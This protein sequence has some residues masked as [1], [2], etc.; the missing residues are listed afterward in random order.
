MA[1]ELLDS[2]INTLENETSM[3]DC[4]SCKKCENVSFADVVGACTID[5]GGY[6]GKLLT[7]ATKHIEAAKDKGYFT[8]ETAGQVF[9]QA[10]VSSMQQAIQFELSHG[11]AQREICL[12]DAQTKHEYNKI[13]LENKELEEKKKVNDAQIEKINKDIEMEDK[14]IDKIT[15]DIANAADQLAEKIRL[16]DAQIAKWE[17]DCENNEKLIDA[18]A[19]LYGRQA[20]GFGDNVRQKLFDTQAQAFAMVFEAVDGLSLPACLSEDALNDSYENITG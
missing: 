15:A 8:E 18:Q 16:D 10:L 3:H 2:Y 1:D 19:A 12:I 4:D 14:Q 20:E 13:V 17:C 11:K 9:A 6:F 7:L 5:N